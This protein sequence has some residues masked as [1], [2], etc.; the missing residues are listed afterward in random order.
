MNRSRQWG[1]ILL[2]IGI[3]LLIGAVTGFLKQ[4]PQGATVTLVLAVLCLVGGLYL[5]RRR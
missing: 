5:T 3:G 4:D 2:G 1:Q